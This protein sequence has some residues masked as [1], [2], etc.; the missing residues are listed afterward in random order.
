MIFN[1]NFMVI[2]L[3]ASLL[4]AACS[5]TPVKKNEAEVPPATSAE[6]VSILPAG[7]ALANPYLQSRAGISRQAQQNFNDAVKA[8]DNKQWAQAESLLLKVTAENP[9]LSGAWLNLG[10][11]YRAQDDAAKAEEYFSKAIAANQNN[12][13]AYNALGLLKREAGDFAAAEVNYNKALAVWPWHPASH[14]NIA[15]LYDLYMGKESEALAHYEAYQE[16]VG[17]S[18]NNIASWIADLQRRLGVAPKPKVVPQADATAS[19]NISTDEAVDSAES[20]GQE[21]GNE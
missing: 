3:C 6:R 1:R 9:N 5:S 14:K 18:D 15:I 13:D 21:A 4:L 11:I 8:M 17:E 16:L 12:L 20:E 10:F 2:G 19:E 7:P